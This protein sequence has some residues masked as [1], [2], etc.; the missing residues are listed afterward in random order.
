MARPNAAE[1]LAVARR[2]AEAIRLKATGQTWQQV[3]DALGYSSRGAACQDIK[4]ALEQ[5]RE[6]LGDAVATYRGLE[7]ARLERY[8]EVATEVL[9]RDHVA[10]SQGRIVREGLPYIDE[11]TGRA[12]IDEGRGAPVLDDMPKLKAVGELRQLSESRR[13]LLGLD[14]PVRQEFGG[15][16]TVKHVVEAEDFNTGDLT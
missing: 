4:R 11:E 13:K 10:V 6:D 7:L 16:L 15:D 14:V 1:Q 8:T 9:D 12:K 3:A 2:R 5:E